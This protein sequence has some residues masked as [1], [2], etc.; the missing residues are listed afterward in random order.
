VTSADGRTWSAPQDVSTDAQG[1]AFDASVSAYGQRADIGWQSVTLQDGG[2][3]ERFGTGNAA[4]DAYVATG[5]AGTW[6]SVNVNH[7][8]SDPAASAQNNL[9]AQF[10]GDYASIISSP[11]EA[12][13]VYTDSRTG[14]GC[15]DVDEFQQFV[16]DNG[17]PTGEEREDG[18][19]DAGR[20]D[21]ADEVEPAPP[22]D[23]PPQFG[24]TD[25]YVATVTP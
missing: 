15:P 23:C 21:A 4:V 12:R 6:A 16:I 11:T 5:A 3:A 10:W 25:A 20:E 18:G 17:L 24:N 2:S 13:Y 7:G 8:V 9:R 14:E 22:T 1:Y 19:K